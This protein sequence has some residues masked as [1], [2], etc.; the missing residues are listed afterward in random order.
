VKIINIIIV[1]EFTFG[2]LYRINPAPK[3]ITVLFALAIDPYE[4]VHDYDFLVVGE[5]LVLGEHLRLDN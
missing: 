4:P 2:D 3:R 5:V 1:N